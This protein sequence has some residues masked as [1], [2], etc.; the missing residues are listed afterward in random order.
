MGNEQPRLP[1]PA[2]QAAQVWATVNATVPVGSL[3]EVHVP[4]RSPKS[5]MISESGVVVW[6]DGAVVGAVSGVS[7][8]NNDGRFVVFAT[9]SG[10]YSFSTSATPS[11]TSPLVV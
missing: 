4:V 3:G 5:G 7:Y 9:G 10:N 2:T 1:T 8:V 6:R 11:G